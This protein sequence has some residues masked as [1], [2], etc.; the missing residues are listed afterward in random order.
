MRIP[1][2][3][4]LFN[5]LVWKNKIL[6]WDDLLKWGCQG[7]G[8]CIFCRNSLKTANHIL[9][10][11]PYTAHIWGI[12]TSLWHFPIFLVSNLQELISQW[13]AYTTEDATIPLFTTWEIWKA[14]TKHIF[15][16][17][18]IDKTRICYNVNNWMG[19]SPPPKQSIWNLGKTRTVPSITLPAGWF[20][21]AS[22]RGMCGCG[23]VL[24]LDNH[25][26]YTLHWNGGPCTNTR[27]KTMALWWFLGIALV[28]KRK[29][30]A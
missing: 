27:A 21:G 15:E 7:L 10:Q 13:N 8:I 4:I 20:D 1:I 17:M 2:K 24:K 11:C 5:S 25:T 28:C 26:R 14:R 22:Q 3:I 6:T 23:A 9:F 16:G 18:P 19:V 12:L 29:E 30:D